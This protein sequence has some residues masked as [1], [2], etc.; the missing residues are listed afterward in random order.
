MGVTRR[1]PAPSREPSSLKSCVKS[2]PSEHLIPG[3]PMNDVDQGKAC[4][5]TGCSR[6]IAP[7][8]FITM[9]CA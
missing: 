7:L 4:A 5:H 9:L 6:R 2:C 8:T 1:L 3:H